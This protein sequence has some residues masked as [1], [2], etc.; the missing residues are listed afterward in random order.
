MFDSRQG[1][2]IISSPVFSRAMGTN[3]PPIKWVQ[4]F[5]SGVLKWPSL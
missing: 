1:K 4:I 2:Y 5:L 3:V